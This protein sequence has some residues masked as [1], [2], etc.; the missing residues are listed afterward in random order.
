[1]RLMMTTTPKFM[2]TPA[3]L[4]TRLPH[5][6]LH[7]SSVNSIKSIKSN[8]IEVILFQRALHTARSIYDKKVIVIKEKNYCNTLVG[9]LYKIYF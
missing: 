3:V 2:I 7:L 6:P 9:L 5:R 8:Q 4:L 1:M